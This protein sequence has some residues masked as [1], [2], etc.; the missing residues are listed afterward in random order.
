M[1]HPNQKQSGDGITQSRS[2]DLHQNCF[3]L[4]AVPP[5]FSEGRVFM[6]KAEEMGVRQLIE[7]FV[8]YYSFRDSSVLRSKAC[9]CD[10]LS[11]LP[12]PYNENGVNFKKTHDVS[13]PCHRVVVFCGT[14]ADRESM[15][16]AAY[17]FATVCVEIDSRPDSYLYSD[18]VYARSIVRRSS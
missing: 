6:D 13:C 4:A 11:Q 8:S 2:C 5:A 9:L 10:A 1:S 17:Y 16:W 12:A 3:T 18:V 15:R 7:M 14:E